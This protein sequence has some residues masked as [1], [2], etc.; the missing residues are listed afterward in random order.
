MGVRKQMKGS[1][2]CIAAFAAVWVNAQPYQFA[3]QYSNDIILKDASKREEF[4][5]K[6]MRAESRFMQSGVAFNALSGLTYDGHPI[7]FDTGELRGFP[8]NWSA[9]S[10]ESLHL[11]VLALAV[12]GNAKIGL[13]TSPEDPSRA[14]ESALRILDRKMTSYEKFNRKYP[15][16]GGFLPW[17]VVSDEGM[18]PTWDWENRAPAL[19][20]G[21]LAWALM[22]VSHVLKKQGA[23][24]LAKRYEDY[25]KLLG[26]N[27]VPLFFDS[28]NRRIRGVSKIRDTRSQVA[29]G[30]YSN[31]ETVYHITDP[32]EG[33]L[34]TLFMSLYGSWKSEA[35]VHMIWKSKRLDKAF[36]ETQEGY[37][38]TVRRGFWYSVH[39]MW[40]FLVLPYLDDPL[41]A[42]VF[43]N[44]EKA[45]SWYSAENG[46]PGLMASVNEPV[47]G[48]VTGRYLSDVGIPSLASVPVTRQ[49]V[50]TP[51]AAFPIIIADRPVGMSWLRTMLTG[52]SMLG[53]YGATEAASVDGKRIAPL[54]TWD[55]KIPTLLALVGESTDF[56]R[57]VLKSTG[58]YDE[59]LGFIH[60]EY[61]AVFGKEALLG[62][63][64][65]FRTPTAEIPRNLPDFDVAR[66][67]TDILRSGKFQSGGDLKEEYQFS[68]YT[69]K[70][71]PAKGFV[72]TM[73]QPTDLKT[74]RYI[75][76]EVRQ[77]EGHE[78]GF[79][80]ELKNGQ[81]QLITD[82][83]VW[84]KIP[85]TG[86]RFSHYTV[87][88][89]PL[90]TN[91]SCSA[92][93]FVFSDPEGTL[94]FRRATIAAN[95]GEKAKLLSYDSV[96]FSEALAVEARTERLDHGR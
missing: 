48:N 25:W 33:E 62:E 51:Y 86:E 92:T 10:K 60:E 89:G 79:F 54:L 41:V 50:V 56:M 17:F 94:E 40:N 66:K 4:V 37:K 19:D 58:K 21:Q 42:R 77:D 67:V 13:L 15:G 52:P 61:A 12:S 49:D 31:E 83:K 47:S 91:P 22:Q 30:N 11:M 32:Y 34:M 71:A 57:E 59:F 80:I 90:V 53:P 43:K 72:W 16:F 8:K 88:L 63:N 70:L 29:D 82:R 5:H 39:E 18:E 26:K 75:N 64:L 23:L 55:G 14:R 44:G 45:R 76:L 38:I 73:I 6:L 46:I 96:S 68:D 93:I 2:I 28:E 81:D 9:P 87:D 85:Y 65:S 36:Y 3:R 74:Y 78:R 27:C 24:Q 7:D 20:N 84:V 69:L 95:R 35:D 1:V